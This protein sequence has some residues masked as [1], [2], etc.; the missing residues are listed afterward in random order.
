LIEYKKKHR[1][2]RIKMLDET[3]KTIL[4]D[5][6]LTVVNLVFSV[7]GKIGKCPWHGAKFVNL[8][9]SLLVLLF[10]FLSV[11]FFL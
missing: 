11:F 7:C 6:S 10:S 3:V 1:P 5:E 2:L 9:R 8:F 4:V